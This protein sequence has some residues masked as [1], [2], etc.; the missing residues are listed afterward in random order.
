M[1]CHTEYV[2]QQKRAQSGE[3]SAAQT[4]NSITIL[5]D[6]SKQ[7]LLWAV[8]SS[9]TMNGVLQRSDLGLLLFNIFVN[10]IDDEIKHTLSKCVDNKLSGAAD[11]TEEKDSIQTD[12]DGLEKWAHVSLTKFNKAKCNKDW[13]NF[14]R[15]VLQRS[16]WMFQ[17]MRTCTWAS[18]VLL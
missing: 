12:L 8:S 7:Q 6:V 4:T 10:S 9:R 17:R 15:A 13:E 3:C 18:S 1:V 2:S 5:H 14:L 16:T 11:L